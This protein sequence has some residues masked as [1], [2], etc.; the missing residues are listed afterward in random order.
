V[1][2]VPGGI[3]MGHC[4]AG[5]E[6]YFGFLHISSFEVIELRYYKTYSCFALIPEKY[7][8]FENP[9]KQGI[10]AY[11]TA[12]ILEKIDY[13]E[14][15]KNF[16]DFLKDFTESKEKQ[17][18]L[19]YKPFRYSGLDDNFEGYPIYLEHWDEEKIK[20]DWNFREDKCF[21]DGLKKID[22]QDFLGNWFQSNDIIAYEF[23]LPETGFILI[24]IFKKI[25]DKWYLYEFRNWAM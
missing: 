2:S 11:G 9:L 5:Y 13:K 15:E 22:S 12:K 17:I 7:T 20:N 16:L 10:T 8:Y 19:L 4:G 6:E 25:N 18:A 3:G 14:L 1:P 24:F 21:I 23:S